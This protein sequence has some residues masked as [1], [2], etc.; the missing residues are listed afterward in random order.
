MLQGIRDH[1][2]T[3]AVANEDQLA[4]LW[5]VILDERD[6]VLGLSRQTEQGFIAWPGVR[7]KK[8]KWRRKQQ[9]VVL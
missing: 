4:V 3:D 1:L 9:L 2:A 7:E 6:L 5:N 8:Q